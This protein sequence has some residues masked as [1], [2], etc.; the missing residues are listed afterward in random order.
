METQKMKL[1]MNLIL[2]MLYRFKNLS[3]ISINQ[4]PDFKA[5]NKKLFNQFIFNNIFSNASGRSF[6]RKRYLFNRT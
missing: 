3:K 1:K 2:Q 4:K 5:I 6:R